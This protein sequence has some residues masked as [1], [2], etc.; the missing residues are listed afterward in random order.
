MAIIKL[1]DGYDDSK[2][3]LSITTDGGAGLNVDGGARHDRAQQDVVVRHAE[4]PQLAPD[5]R[6]QQPFDQT[7][8]NQNQL[9]AVRVWAIGSFFLVAVAVLVAVYAVVARSVSPVALPI[10]I[11]A[12]L[13]CVYLIAL[14]LVPR[15]NERGVVGFQALLIEFLKIVVGGK[16]MKSD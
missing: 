16:S 9:R 12:A 13:L 2:S 6:I 1:G 5:M 4:S 7:R 8:P 10:V 3:S 11:G 15:E 14:F